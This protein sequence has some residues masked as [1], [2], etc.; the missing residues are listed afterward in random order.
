MRYVKSRTAQERIEVEHTSE[1]DGF[2]YQQPDRPIFA[3]PDR[4]L[5]QY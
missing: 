4:G 2:K 3:D 5:D 1:L